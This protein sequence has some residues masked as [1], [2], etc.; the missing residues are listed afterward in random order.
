MTTQDLTVKLSLKDEASKG[1]GK[2]AGNFKKHSSKITQNMGKIALVGGAALTGAAAAALALSDEF[3]EAENSIAAG[4]GATGENL[5]ALKSSFD[6]VFK[7]VPN[8]SQEV[9]SAIADVNTEF[10]FTG[11]KLES[12][13]EAAL[14]ASRVM[15]EDLGKVI[16]LTADT[17][18]AFGEPAEGAE[19]L[20]DKLTV[21]SQA[22]GVSMT[23]LAKSATKF[24]PE[25]QALGLPMDES[26][27]LIANME[28]AGLKTKSM[29]PGLATA[30]DKMAKDGVEN[31]SEAL[32]AAITDLENTDDAEERLKKS[33]ELFGGTAG[34]KF[35]DAIGKGVFQLDDMMASMGESEGSLAALGESTL[36]S[37]DK[38]DI[39][40]NK[41]KSMI[42]P[43]AGFAGQA[44]PMLMALPVLT[45][46]IGGLSTVM[47]G[48]SLSMGPILIAVVAIAAAIAVGILVWKNWDKIVLG[49]KK[50]WKIVW[51]GL[52]GP[53]KLVV[54]MLKGYINVWI[55]AI[56]TIIRGLNLIAIKVPKWVP[57]FGGKG[58]SFN[59]PEIPKLAAGGIIT[60]PTIAQIGEAGPEAVIPLSKGAGLGTTININFP[61][62]S[63][64]I[65][66]NEASANLL[67]DQIT[68]QIRGVL[69]SQGA[70]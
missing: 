12:V 63:T 16:K 46:M 56:N 8:D 26:I 38:L 1:M 24:A 11:A 31:I 47:G 25:L 51:D 50:T 55:G 70:F 69:R 22:S 37:A 67:A 20:M 64:V 28:A 59:I 10:G 32:Q 45:T 65:L 49:F 52:A 29:M 41:A 15:G 66:D 54:D 7:D 27:A 42:A 5:E 6:N 36:T 13:T 33:M 57:K 40:K 17:L 48:L 4:T 9:A 61:Q 2:A 3:K 23:D 68:Q 53:V 35:S 18:I 58:F 39:M 43:I 14:I 34:L 62:G 60:S 30:M 19:K 44:G 21:A